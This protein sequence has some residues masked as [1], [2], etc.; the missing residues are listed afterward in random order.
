LRHEIL[1]EEGQETAALYALGALSQ[2]EARA[3]EAHLGLGCSVCQKQLDEFGYVTGTLAESIEAVTPPTYLRDL[4]KVRIEKESESLAQSKGDRASIIPFPDKQRAAS[5]ATS[6]TRASKRQAWIPWA[7]AASMLVALLISLLMWQSDRRNLQASINESKNETL[8]AVN[9]NKE[10]KENLN[11]Q[12][13][14]GQELAQINAILSSPNQYEIVSLKA[15]ENAPATLSSA[16]G[17]VYWN[18]RDKKWVVTADLPQPPEGK[19]YQLWFVTTDKPV[20][21]GMIRPDETGH[22]FLATDVPSNVRTVVAAAIT[23]EPSGGS[24]QPTMPIIAMGKP[25]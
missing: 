22:G 8:A 10:I 12:S 1:T 17:T 7:I 18:K 4:L 19:A 21:A 2:N 13:A 15:T 3:F 20:S 14:R 6:T 25:A 5:S 23:L 9:E 16:S 11:K 24:L